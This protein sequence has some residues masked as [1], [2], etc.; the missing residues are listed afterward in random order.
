MNKIDFSEIE[1]WE[2]FEDLVAQYFRESK[3]LEDN[4]L[5]EVD[6]D[7][8]GKGQDGGRD[9][10]LNFR[11]NDSIV[12]FERKWVVQ[13]K[14]HE[15]LTKS[16]LDKISIST[17][18]EE[19]DADGYLL[20]C[21]NS[22]TSGV[23]NTFENLRNKCRRKYKYELWK[24]NYFCQKLY[25]TTDLQEHYFPKFFEYKKLRAERAGIKNILTE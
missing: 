7:P 24:G 13:C 19:Y 22:V 3:N 21:K 14:F 4:H 23:T 8:T 6:V 18:I 25:K 16:D 15:T 1:S 10:I 5:V 20:V 9:I 2:Q 12:P 17:L 11:I